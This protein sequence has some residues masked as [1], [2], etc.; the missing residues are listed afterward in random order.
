MQRVPHALRAG[1]E[2]RDVAGRFEGRVRDHGTVERLQ[3]VAGGVGERDHPGHAA[4]VSQRGRLTLHSDPSLLKAARQRIEPRRICYLPAEH[5]GTRRDSTVDEQTL[6]AVI[7]AERARPA[8]AVHLLH[9]EP[10][11]RKRAPVLDLV[12]S[13][14]QIAECL[15]F[16]S[17]PPIVVF[18]RAFWIARYN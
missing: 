7:H 15:Y 4:R 2:A 16:H 18:W 10:G 3:P 13:N 9:P 5:L 6:L 17:E 8:A 12:R 14:P 11:G 1:A